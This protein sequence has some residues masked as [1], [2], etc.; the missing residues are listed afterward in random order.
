MD[1]VEAVAAGGETHLYDKMRSSLGRRFGPLS[2]CSM[3]VAFFSFTSSSSSFVVFVF[4]F[5]YFLD[6][7]F[8]ASSKRRSREDYSDLE[9]EPDGDEAK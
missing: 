2:G 1:Q 7:L 8:H 4:V 5:F 9:V 6:G 3:Q